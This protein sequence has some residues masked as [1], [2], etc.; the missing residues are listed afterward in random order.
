MVKVVPT[1]TAMFAELGAELPLMT[2]MLIAIS[3]FFRDSV[4]Y[5]VGV[6][7]ALILAYKLYG[8]TEE[9]RMNVAQWKRKIPVLGNINV[10][11]SAVQFADTMTTMLASGIPLNKAVS[12]TAKV[13]DNYYVSQEVGKLSAKLEEGR[14]LGASMRESGCMP[15][16]LTDMVGVGEETGEL[17]DTLDTVA[18][19][20]DNELELAVTKAVAMLEPGLLI[21]IAIIAGF[22]VIAIYMSMFEMYSVM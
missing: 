10:L 16:I 1:F 8:N 6:V 17:K 20:Y 7:A 18:A 21:F 12:I 22:I 4:W 5:I 13:I 15:D 2:R 3:N 19:Y 9:G 14:S 11:N